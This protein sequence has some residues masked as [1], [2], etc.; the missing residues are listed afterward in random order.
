MKIHF[1][2][3][4]LLVQ[5]LDL[6]IIKRVPSPAIRHV[7][8]PALNGLWP[9]HLMVCCINVYSIFMLFRLYHHFQYIY[10]LPSMGLPVV[11]PIQMKETQK[12]SAKTDSMLRALNPL[13]A[14]WSI[15]ELLD[16]TD[17]NLPHTPTH[18]PIRVRD[19]SLGSRRSVSE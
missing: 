9:P 2:D 16:R 14:C 10:V 19:R 3:I 17:P 11:W 18:S 7:L 13:R 6:P 4:F 15:A 5:T 1:L 12:H 8:A